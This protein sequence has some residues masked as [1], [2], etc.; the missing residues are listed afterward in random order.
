MQ[1]ILNFDETCLSVDGSEGRRGGRPEIV[2][3]DPRFPMTGKATNKDSLTATLISGSNAAGEALPPHFQF[4]TAAQSEENMRI[5]NDM[6]Q[7]IPNT[8]GK[9]GCEKE[10]QW[11]CTIGMNE[12]GGMD[13]NEFEQYIFTGLVLLWPHV[14]DIP[15]KQV[16]LKA[17]SGPG[18]GALKLLA[19]LSH[20]NFYLY[21]GVPNTTAISQETD[22]N[23]G[24]FKSQF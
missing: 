2:L 19:C 6:L 15:G 9:F 20:L 16:M 17:D 11:P 23:Y 4:Q 10:K 5:H 7:W 24:P 8:V 18:R 12:K 13:D 21:P 3:H 22:I 1:N 14:K